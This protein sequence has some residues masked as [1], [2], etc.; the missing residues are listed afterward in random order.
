MSD[1]NARNSSGLTPREENRLVAMMLNPRRRWKVTKSAKTLAMDTIIKNLQ[2]D[3]GRVSNGAV[4]NLLRMERQN[5]QDEHKLID[6]AI[7]DMHGGERAAALA[8]AL[9]QARN[10]ETYGH[11]RRTAM[12]GHRSQSG[13][14][15][16]GRE[17][18]TMAHG[19]APRA[20]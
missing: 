5:Q 7:P 9:E 10:D 1:G 12:L 11:V 15:G 18:R 8:A 4:L 16:D 19:E 6:K 17:S 3:D 2:S 14:D 20:G 13:A